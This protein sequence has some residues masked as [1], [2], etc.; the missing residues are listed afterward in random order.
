VILILFQEKRTPLHW[1]AGNGRKETC[2]LLI[3]AKADVN[4]IDKVIH[5]LEK[6]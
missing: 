2:A 3:E 4:A 5:Y 6:K 1:S